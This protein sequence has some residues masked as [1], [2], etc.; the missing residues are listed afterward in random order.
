[1]VAALTAAVLGSAVLV[2][3]LPS[4]ARA[5]GSPRRLTVYSTPGEQAYINN[6]DD[7]ARGDVDNPFGTH[8]QAPGAST[9]GPFPGDEA[10]FSLNIYADAALTR[11]VGLAVIT[12]QYSFGRNGFCDA[13]FQMNGGTLIAAGTVGFDA[14]QFALAVT[15]G[16][17]K[18]S[19]ATGDVEATAA[20]QAGPAP[21][22]SSTT[23]LR[24]FRFESSC[25]G[26]GAVSVRGPLVSRHLQ[27]SG[28]RLSRGAQ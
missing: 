6:D 23:D 3:V 20:R 14:T 24:A 1:M 8:S 5:L 18:Y 16:Y 11:R 10:I 21:L 26:T 28:P 25:A 4:T 27:A 22:R 19:G 7:E 9:K 17:G 2:A 15:G 13:S 12:C